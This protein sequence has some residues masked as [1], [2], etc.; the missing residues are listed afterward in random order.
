MRIVFFSHPDFTVSPSMPRYASWLADG[1][2]ARGHEVELW[3]PKAVL[4]SLPVFNSL[5]KWLGYIDQYVLF[6]WQARRKIKTLPQRTLFVFTDHALG[7]WVPLTTGKP[8][9]IHCHDF[10]AQRSALGDIPENLTGWTGKQYQG[11][12]RW[13]YSKGKNFISVSQKT[14]NDLHTFLKTAPS[15]SDVVYNGLNPMYTPGDGEC[16]RRFLTEQFGIKLEKGY[17]LHVGGNQWYKNRKGVIE[18]YDAWRKL[19]HHPMPLLL[20]GEKPSAELAQL[21][22]SSA[23]RADIHFLSGVSDQQ[24][25]QAYQGAAVFLF[26]SLAEGFGWP[27]IEAMACG[28][29]VVTTNEAPMTEIAGKAA[30]FIPRKPSVDLAGQQW[31]TEAAASVEKIMNESAAERDAFLLEGLETAKKYNIE[32]TTDRIEKIYESIVNQHVIRN[33]AIII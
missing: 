16:A 4:F 5:K 15:F 24:V 23:F 17:W 7:P 21:A 6:A 18:V 2:R 32:M 28:C 19:Y 26:P 30:A 22:A 11:Y 14:Q 31:A 29:R 20:I 3:K 25:V 33:R 1:M 27:I 8:H 13:G 9:V 12:I 10:L